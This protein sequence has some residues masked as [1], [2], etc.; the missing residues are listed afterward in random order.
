MCSFF[1]NLFTVT[2]N[3]NIMYSKNRIGN[4][5]LHSKLALIVFQM[6]SFG[7]IESAEFR[8]TSIETSPES[9]LRYVP[10]YF[11]ILNV[12]SEVHLTD[13][14]SGAIR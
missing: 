13:V 5:N 14:H 11:S 7:L 3:N 8:E 4:R 1:D 12:E 6:N 10:W 2:G 9:C